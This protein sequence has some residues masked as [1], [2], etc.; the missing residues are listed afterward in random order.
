MSFRPRITDNGSSGSPGFLL[1]AAGAASAGDAVFQVT[2]LGTQSKLGVV[3][4]SFRIA[5]DASTLVACVA[6]SFKAIRV[7][8]ICATSG[9]LCPVIAAFIGEILQPNT[10]AYM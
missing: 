2:N 10:S 6:E 7:S 4:A 5:G 8:K 3:T 9:A 1:I